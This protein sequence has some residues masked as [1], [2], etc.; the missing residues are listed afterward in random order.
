M[1][2]QQQQQQQQQKQPRLSTPQSRQCTWAVTGMAA[3]P[4]LLLLLLLLLRGVWTLLMAW[5]QRKP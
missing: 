5:L 3:V 4:P 1:Q 2:Q